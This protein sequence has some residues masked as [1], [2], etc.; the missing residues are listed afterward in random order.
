MSTAEPVSRN[1]LTMAC[2]QCSHVNTLIAK[3]CGGCGHT[4]F[5]QCIGCGQDVRLNEKFCN[6]CGT[7]LESVLRSRVEQA[8]QSIE[9]AVRA[10]KEHRYADAISRLEVLTRAPDY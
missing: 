1:A 10:T 5:E 6:G 4:L 7:N 8:E 9:A 2:G 3:F